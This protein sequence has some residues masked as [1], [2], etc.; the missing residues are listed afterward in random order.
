MPPFMREGFGKQ[1]PRFGKRAAPILH[2]QPFAHIVG[3]TRPSCP[4]GQ[5]G[6]HPACEVRRQ[7][8][9]CAHIGWDLRRLFCGA[10]DQIKVAD[11]LHL[12]RH[13]RKD[14]GITGAQ[15]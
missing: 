11:S 8:H 12:H 1:L 3:E 7:W 4:V 10:H 14:K 15:L 6:A 2:F 13:P 5:E 9:P